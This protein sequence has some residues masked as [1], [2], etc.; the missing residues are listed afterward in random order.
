[1][2]LYSYLT[3]LA[4]S[5]LLGATSLNAQ[6]LAVDL[7]AEAAILMNADTGDILYEK[8]AYVQM[9]PASITKIA[10]AAYLLSVKGDALDEVAT[11]DFEAL[12]WV[13]DEAKKRSNYTLPAYRL[14][15]SGTHMGIKRGE[16]LT[17]RELLYGMMMVSAND[18]SNVIA[19][20]VSGTVPQFMDDLN[21]YLKQIGCQQ[22]NFTS[23]HGLPDPKHIT[24]AYDMA[25][26]ARESLKNPI[27]RQVVS[28][29]RR[30]RPKTN[31]QEPSPLLQSN[32]LLRSG[33]YYYPKAIGIKTGYHSMAQNTIVAAAKQDDRTLIVVLLKVKERSDLF[34]DAIALFDAAFKQPKIQ[35]VLVRAGPQKMQREL[36]GATALLTPYVA[37]DVTIDY[38]PAEEPKVRCLLT[39]DEVS[40]P[41]ARGQ[42]IGELAIETTQGRPIQR[43][44]LLAYEDV[45]SSFFYG[46]KSFFGTPKQPGLGLKILG[47][48][49]CLFVFLVIGRQLLKR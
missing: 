46:I 26:L 15:P 22:T 25:V 14:E 32:R 23:P 48:I 49:A 21:A 47:A 33:K 17:L 13:T 18:A 16:Q 4:L 37:E 8:N 40:P 19:M 39:W 10:T 27:F 11:A 38:Y 31:K 28:T 43:V 7:H 36:E 44:P 20:H 34:Q 3:Y 6:Q 41:I 35:K 45:D 30:T 29:V 42:R 5:A 9:Q 12:G 24:T 2:K 1:M